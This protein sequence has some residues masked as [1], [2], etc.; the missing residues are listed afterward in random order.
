MSD[1]DHE[2]VWR[3][4][5]FGI[6]TF[7][8]DCTH[9][10]DDARFHMDDRGEVSEECLVQ[11]WFDNDSLDIVNNSDTPT[12]NSLPCWTTYSYDGEPTLVGHAQYQDWKEGLDD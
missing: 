9:G 12:T 3:D 2:V 6:P 7:D 8:L 1:H 11:Q 4:L 5:A 10:D